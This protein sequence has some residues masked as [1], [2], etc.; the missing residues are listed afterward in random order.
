VLILT[1]GICLLLGLVCALCAVRYD[2][3]IMGEARQGV[4]VLGPEEGSSEW[5]Q[6]QQQRRW[7]DR[8]FYGGLSLTAI[9]VILQTLVS[10]LP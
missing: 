4:A 5:V 6:K 3:R 9:G 8:L 2:A 10:L 1:G 7:A